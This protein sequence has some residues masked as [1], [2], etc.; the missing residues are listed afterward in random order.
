MESEKEI[1]L[2]VDDERK[3]LLITENLID[4]NYQFIGVSSGKE[5]LHK[6]E[7]FVPAVILLDIMMPEIDGYEVCKI[8]KNDKRFDLTKIILVSGKAMLEERL[9][10]YEM[11]ADDYVTKPFDP[12]ELLAK[13]N[14]F[15]Q[16]FTT[17]KKLQ[18]LNESLED[19]IKFRTD[20][21]IQ[22]E[23]MRYIGMNSAQIVHNL[24]NPITVINAYTKILLNK[25]PEEEFLTKI[26]NGV[27]TLLDIIKSILDAVQG[28]Q[29]DVIDNI[30]LNE[31][32]KTEINF[33]KINDTYKYKVHTETN[34]QDIPKYTGVRVHFNQVLGNLI[35]NATEAMADSGG[36]LSISTDY[37]EGDIRIK[38]SDTGTGISQDHIEKMFTPLFTTK[39]G[40]GD[41]E[42]TGTGLGLSFCKKMIEGYKGSISVK[43]M[44]GEGT[45]FTI[46]LPCTELS[47]GAGEEQENKVCRNAR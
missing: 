23:R 2:S 9:K 7:G 24:K 14:I 28:T 30:D 33:I 4:D 1:I 32:I 27:T 29:E 26:D 20:Q 36:T 12:D 15:V 37:E 31:V 45:T 22:S 39:K 38:I 5:A 42:M 21:L 16:L 41:G 18:R 40:A 6:M 11:G 43:S 44:L 10:G 8:I 34:F 35:K 46:L 3:N 19:E 13:I 17:Q 47:S 25:Y